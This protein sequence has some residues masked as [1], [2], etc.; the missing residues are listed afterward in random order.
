MI[1]PSP[2]SVFKQNSITLKLIDEFRLE[3]AEKEKAEKLKLRQRKLA[4]QL[5]KSKLKVVKLVAK[6]VAKPTK[7]VAK[8]KAKP[9]AKPK[10]KSKPETEKQFSDRAIGALYESGHQSYSM[11]ESG[12][13]FPESLQKYMIDIEVWNQ[14]VYNYSNL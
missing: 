3:Q 9:V 1:K 13:C 7:P 6:P 2:F 10:A 14:P 11:L 8:P 4:K 12:G 5:K